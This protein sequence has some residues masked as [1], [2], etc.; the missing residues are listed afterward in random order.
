MSGVIV[1]T[2]YGVDGMNDRSR[3][4][5]PC[6]IDSVH[7]SSVEGGFDF[8]DNGLGVARSVC[9]EYADKVKVPCHA[10]VDGKGVTMLS[11]N[12][13]A[14]W[15]ER[16]VDRRIVGRLQDYSDARIWWIFWS[17]MTSTAQS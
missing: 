4:H 6:P 16:A 1:K 12:L 9:P 14:Q 2:Y 5:S 8:S 17:F 11:D 10:S 13:S 15:I 3:K 7:T